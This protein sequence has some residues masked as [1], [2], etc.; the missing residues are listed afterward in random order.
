MI[1]MT[2]LF[3]LKDDTS[4]E[5]SRDIILVVDDDEGIRDM[6]TVCIETQ[7]PYRVLSMES[8]KETLERI[9][10]VKAAHPLLFIFDYFLPTMT[11]INLYDHLHGLEAF[12]HIPAI[13]ITAASP[14]LG[15]DTAAAERGLVLLAK[16][17]DLD[18]LFDGIAQLLHPHQL[19]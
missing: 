12:A 5:A 16:P 3:D 2:C 1:D 11:A 19:I 9:E 10:E 13:I 7:T 18:E 6:L 17:F 15:I 4:Q 8:G 14:Y